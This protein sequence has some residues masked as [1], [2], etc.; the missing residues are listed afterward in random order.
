MADERVRA[1]GG[2]LVL[3][4]EDLDVQRSRHE[5]YH[6]ILEDLAWLDIRW[7]EGPDVGGPFGSYSQSERHQHYLDAWRALLDGG[8]IYTCR[9]S[10]KDLAQAVSAPQG[11]D[12]E[13]PIYPGTCRP[14]TGETRQEYTDPAQT[15]WRFRVPDG[16]VIE[17]DDRHFGRQRFTAGTDF[18]DFL[19]WRRDDVPSYQLACVVD[20]IAMQHHRSGPRSRP[21]SVDR[22]PD[23]SLSR[24][25][26]QAARVVPLSSDHRRWRTASC[27]APRCSGNPHAAGTGQTA[28]GHPA[29]API[30]AVFRHIIRNPT[31]CQVN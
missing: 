29:D 12:D 21:A 6:A 19:V 4:N 25:G 31:N 10:R 22:S 7:Q 20:D 18:G 28:G 15:N 27:Q 9:C 1:S 13:G 30:N 14:K 23:P 8:F 2:T 24:T 16:E 5:F 3:R 17:F 26:S 11:N